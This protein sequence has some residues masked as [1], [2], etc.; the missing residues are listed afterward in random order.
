MK[1]I[2]AMMLVVLLVVGMAGCGNM[3]M[4]LGSFTYEK[5]H[6]D[7]HHY[8][9]CLTIEKWYEN[10]SGIEVLTKEAG[11]VFASEGTYILLG[12]DKDCPL[13]TERREGE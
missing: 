13:C 2:I 4:G 11:S 3:S 5:I 6:I 1:K 9:G 12:G 7:T 8:S 10:G